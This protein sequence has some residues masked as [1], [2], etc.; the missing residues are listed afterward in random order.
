MK[1]HA[2][3]IAI[4]VIGLVLSGCDSFLAESI[5]QV[6]SGAVRLNDAPANGIGIKIVPKGARCDV[7]AVETVT[8]QDGSFSFKRSVEIGKLDVIVQD[9][10]LCIGSS[11]NWLPAWHSIYGPAARKLVFQCVRD[12]G[13]WSC[14]AH[15]DGIEVPSH[16]G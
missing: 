1:T 2:A 11:R 4:C 7:A 16:G 12:A 10:T 5:E 9:D 3:P 15:G 8:G 13:A 14:T 6:V